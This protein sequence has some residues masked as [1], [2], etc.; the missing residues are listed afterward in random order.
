MSSKIIL[1][2]GGGHCKSCIDVLEHQN[3]YKIKGILG[4]KN[5][6]DQSV[7]GYPYIG[8][9]DEIKRFGK[10]EVFF[11]ICVGQVKTSWLRVTLFEKVKK[12]GGRFPV[13]ISPGAYVSKYAKIGEGTIIMNRAVINA[14]VRI[15]NN[16]IINTAAVVEHDVSVGDHVHV[17]TNAV[18]NGGVTVGNQ[19]FIGSKTMIKEYIVIGE[20]CI[21]P[22][23]SSIFKNEKGSMES[24]VTKS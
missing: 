10:E 14:D 18:L 3:L 24:G 20:N 9:D 22:A 2:G 15:G 5:S 8:T 1:I 12:A 17:S 19:S 16:C 11:L 13:I 21:I 7:L 6:S 23:G 4:P